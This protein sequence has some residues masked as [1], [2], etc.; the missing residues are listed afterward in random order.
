MTSKLR[1]LISWELQDNWAFPI[2]E[3]VIAITILQ[4]MSINSFF[5][6]LNDIAGPFFAS[7]VF[8]IAI[9]V[10]IVFGRSF[11]EGIEKRKFVVLLSYPVSRTKVFVAK[12]LANLLAIFL[13]F[14]SVLF[15][16]GLSMYM[17]DDVLTLALW[18]FMFV[19][20][21]VVVFFASSLITIISMA[22]KRFGLSVLIFLIYV[23]G[24]EYWL[25]PIQGNVGTNNPLAYLS[26]SLG[27]YGQVDYSYRWFYNRLNIGWF[28]PSVVTETLFLTALCYFLIGGLVLFL[29][30]LFL[31]KRIDL[32]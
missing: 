12:Y 8:V 7:M 6:G 1:E 22:V 10:A 16:E 21:L 9:S 11:G 30:S 17:F 19:Y 32:D 14:G 2:L 28:G 15:A 29:A 27:P 4:V 24:L 18:G 20:L 26:L 3:I 25:N 31:M 5:R 13:I 23:L